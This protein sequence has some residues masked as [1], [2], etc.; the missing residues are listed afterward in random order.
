MLE[1]VPEAVLD[2]AGEG[3][4]REAL[5]AEIA[6]RG[7]GDRVVMHGHV[8]EELKAELL[9][10][11]W[12][13]LTASS[14][15]GWCLTVMEAAMYGTPSAALAVG[16]LP[17]SIEDGRTGLL[18]DDGPGLVEAVRS[19][20][21]RQRAAR[22][23]R[24]DRV[25]PRHRLHV[26][27]HGAGEPRRARARGRLRARRAARVD[28]RLGDAQGRRPRG[29][30]AGLQR[31]RAAVHRAVRPDPR[32]R[33]LRLAGRADLD[34]PDPRGA[35]LGA[36]GRGGAGGRHGHARGGRPAGLDDRG[37]EAGDAARPRR[38]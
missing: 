25:R 9:S 28:A 24:R 6:A 14:A 32:R 30:D 20:V 12:V 38:A 29:R 15:E 35:G 21:D 5:E 31:D 22:A 16:G 34:L 18:A 17:E 37:L 19:I 11:S 2:I 1:A 8:S 7:L 13:N 33:R 4:H 36:A 23:P 10:R 27:A 26:G 3:D